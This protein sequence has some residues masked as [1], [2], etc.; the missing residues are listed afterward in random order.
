MPSVTS[1]SCSDARSTCE[2]D[3]IAPTS[4]GD[5]A[6]RLPDLAR[7]AP[8][9]TSAPASHSSPASSVSLVEHLPRRA[10]TTPGSTPTPAS[11]G[12]SRHASATPCCVEPVVERLLPVGERERVDDRGRRVDL[13]PQRVERDEAARRVIARVGEVARAPTAACRS[14]S[15]SAST[16]RVTADAGLLISWARPAA[17]VP[18][19]DE[20]LALARE[21]VHVADGLEEA[22]DQVDAERE[23][24]AHA[25]AERRP[26]ASAAGVPASRRG[27]C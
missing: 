27:R 14:V 4:V 25:V 9:T 26:T 2:Y 24:R 15:C 23:P 13:A 8:P 20:L 11:V 6:G 3:F 7:A 5:P 10:R 1:T 21:R 18:S 22:F 19:D 17:I 16:A 12:A